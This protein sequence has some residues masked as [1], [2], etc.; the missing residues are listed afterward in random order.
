MLSVVLPPVG[1]L[2]E[3]VLACC[4]LLLYSA[5]VTCC[6]CF[7]CCLNVPPH[8]NRQTPGHP[9]TRLHSLQT[10]FTS[11]TA[12][13]ESDAPRKHAPTPKDNFL[14]TWVL[15]VKSGICGMCATTLKGSFRLSC[16]F[17]DG[18]HGPYSRRLKKGV[19]LSVAWANT[20]PVKGRS[21][22]PDLDCSR[23]IT[24]TASTFF[25]I[26]VFAS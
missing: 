24:F 19:S 3:S 13:I 21:W 5:L 1:L 18:R 9:E 22:C 8:S 2:F 23:L 25:R 11:T 14:I 16:P 12:S 17:S 15:G 20:S 7:A 10:V 26:M 6:V 4:L